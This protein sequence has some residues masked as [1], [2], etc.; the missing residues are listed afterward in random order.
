MKPCYIFFHRW[1][2]WEEY[3]RVVD[4]LVPTDVMRETGISK[5]IRSYGPVPTFKT[6]VQPWQKRQ[7]ER[8]GLAQHRQID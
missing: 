8:C 2:K 3:E 5:I 4:R 7:C 6:C 1:G